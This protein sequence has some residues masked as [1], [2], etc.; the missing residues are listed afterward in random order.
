M[1][2]FGL[3]MTTMTCGSPEVTD[4]TQEFTNGFKCSLNACLYTFGSLPNRCSL[5]SL[6]LDA[7]MVLG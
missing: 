6:F 2:E 1:D 5:D 3:D 4:Q 7:H